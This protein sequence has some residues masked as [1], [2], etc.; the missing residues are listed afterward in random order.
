MY[1][2]QFMRIQMKDQLQEA[3]LIADDLAAGDFTVLCF[4]DFIGNALLGQLLFVA[5]NGRDFGDRV[6]AIGEKFGGALGWDSEGMT[7]SQAALLH[8]SGCQR[9][10]TDHVSN[11]IDVWNVGLIMF[12]DLDEPAFVSLQTD[13][14]DI[15]RARRPVRPIL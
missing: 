10:K 6:N 1:T 8:R 4:A 9:R 15:Q 14:F 12:I 7:G 5:S 3:R 2:Q 11:R 13:G